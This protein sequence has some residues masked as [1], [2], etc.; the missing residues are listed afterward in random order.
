[1]HPTHSE[2]LEMR[3]AKIERIRAEA[4]APKLSKEC[5]AKFDIVVPVY[6]LKNNGLVHSSEWIKVHI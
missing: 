1:V 4:K 2:S 3:A 6:D 5:G